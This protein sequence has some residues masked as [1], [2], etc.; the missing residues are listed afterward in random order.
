[1]DD[2]IVDKK[3]AIFSA[4]VKLINERGFHSIPMS[5]IA[6]EASVA[7][8]TIY[9]HFK[10]KDDLLNKLYLETKKKYSASLMTGYSKDLAY[11]DAFELIWRNSLKYKLDY[12]AEFSVMEQF[13]NSPFIWKDTVEEG[14]KIFDPIIQLVE[15]AKKQK[16][17]KDFPGTVIYA[18]FFAPVGEL[19]KTHLREKTDFSEEEIKAAFEGSWNAI[20]E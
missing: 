8:G 15:G 11:R 18:L 2:K 4:T 19:V 16:I 14:L 13:R 3:E 10:N 7:A 12:A 1:M 5:L 9:L 6:K 17:V 20:K